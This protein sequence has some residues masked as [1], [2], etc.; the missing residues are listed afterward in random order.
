MG[1]PCLALRTGWLTAAH[2]PTVWLRALLNPQTNGVL[3][4]LQLCA[5]RTVTL[6]GLPSA[7]LFRPATM[8]RLAAAAW[9]DWPQAPCALQLPCALLLLQAGLP[10]TPQVQWDL[11]QDNQQAIRQTNRQHEYAC[12]RSGGLGVV[13]ARCCMHCNDRGERW[14]LAGQLCTWSPVQ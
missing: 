1:W 12:R 11:Q 2:A 14:L 7:L 4:V 13:R 9:F 6:C 5:G 3:S 10:A 8:G